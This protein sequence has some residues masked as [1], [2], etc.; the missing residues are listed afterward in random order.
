MVKK[1]KKIIL[2]GVFISI[3]ILLMASSASAVEYRA[4][5]EQNTK[6]IISQKTTNA[7]NTVS[8]K[9]TDLIPAMKITHC[10]NLV[11]LILKFIRLI[12]SVMRTFFGIPVSFLILVLLLIMTA[13]FNLIKIIRLIFSM[14][15]TIVRISGLILIQILKI[16]R[17]PFKLISKSITL[18][19]H[20]IRLIILLPL[21]RIGIYHSL[22]TDIIGRFS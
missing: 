14:L 12:F 19:I 6:E 17:F 10:N 8:E 22:L 18:L 11:L 4:V 20:L 7:I 1:M 16:I 2:L 5:I 21:I 15:G 13:P 3:C 9:L